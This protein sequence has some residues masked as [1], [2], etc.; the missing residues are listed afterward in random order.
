MGSPRAGSLGLPFLRPAPLCALTWCGA[1]HPPVGQ[2]LPATTRLAA[3]LLSS[4]APAS[5]QAWNRAALQAILVS[6]SHGN[7][8]RKGSRH[9]K[10]WPCSPD[11][12]A[13]FVLTA[14]RKQNKH[15]QNP[16]KGRVRESPL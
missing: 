3:H 14:I 4:R 11:V 9:L 13:F 12:E 10:D 6:P 15:T 16:Q 5:P 1:Q 8:T 7:R 2:L